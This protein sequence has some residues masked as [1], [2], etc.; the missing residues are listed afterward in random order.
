MDVDDLTTKLFGDVE[1]TKPTIPPEKVRLVVERILSRNNLTLKSLDETED[2]DYIAKSTDVGGSRIFSF[3]RLESAEKGI[4][5]GSLE[6]F[7][8]EAV[9]KNSDRHI[10]ITDSV[11]TEE[12][13]AFAAEKYIILVDGKEMESILVEEK[14]IEAE[15]A[16]VS[17]KNDREAFKYFN[18]RRIKKKFHV[19]GTEEKIEEI[20]R[21]YS[22]VACYM[23]STVAEEVVEKTRVYVD[24]A[25]GD[26]YSVLGGRVEKSG[27]IRRILSLPDDAKELLLELLEHEKIDEEHVSGKALEILKKRRFVNVERKEK[28]SGILIVIIDEILDA[29]RLVS[30]GVSELGSTSSQAETVYRD[31]LKTTT[32][33]MVS[34][35][36]QLTRF[37]N[38]YDLEFYLRT[39]KPTPEFDRDEIKYDRDEIARI[40]DAITKEQEEIEFKYLIY[41]PYYKCTYLGKDKYRYLRDSELIFKKK[42][43]R[44]TVTVMTSSSL[45]L[46]TLPMLLA[47]ILFIG[48]V[49]TF[50]TKEFI[51]QL[52][53]ENEIIGLIMGAIAGSLLFGSL[54]AAYILGGELLNLGVSLPAVTAFIVTWVTVRIIQYPLESYNFGSRFAFWRNFLSFILSIIVAIVMLSLFGT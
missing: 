22:P 29:L 53:T 20:D 8:N 15:K 17:V 23:V 47:T 36:L 18:I 51:T 6:D 46:Q 9:E 14:E 35:D 31:Q 44:K 7:Y 54:I 3:V 28:S 27:I 52:F 12:A 24:L 25:Y 39:A 4:E 37:D 42:G 26:I 11:F 34:P 19:F 5:R 40:L 16:F 43:K 30:R 50:L 48:L 49:S 38:T 32:R 21:R 13:Q 2:G 41:L 1:P 45:F 33:E 10:F